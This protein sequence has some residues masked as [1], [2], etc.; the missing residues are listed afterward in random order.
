MRDRPWTFREGSLIGAGLI[1]IG[2]ILQLTMGEVKWDL[3]AYPLNVLLAVIFVV[4]ITIAFLLS[5]K[6]SFFRWCTTITAA[7]PTMLWCAVMTLVMGVTSW[8][9][10][11]R[12][13]PMVLCYTFMLFILGMTSLK[14]ISHFRIKDI[15]FLL[16][17]VGLFF[18]L[19]A[20]AL[21]NA[22]VQRMRMEVETGGTA[23]MAFDETTHRVKELD[24][25]IELHGFS[26]DE[27][28]AKL[29]LVDNMTGR[30]VPDGN[31]EQ[32]VL[33]DSIVRCRLLDWEIFADSYM[34]MAAQES[35]AD[36]IRYVEWKETGATTAV[37]VVA[38]SIN[39]D[40]ERDGWVS[41][42]SYMFPYQLLRLDDRYSLV[43]PDREPKRFASEVTICTKSGLIKEGIIEVNKPL[44]ADGW[45][46][47][48]LSYDES[49]GRWSDV[50]V[51]EL[52]RDPWLP[53]VYA[54]II[55]MLTG[56]I[57][58]FATAG[59]RRKEERL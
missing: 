11:L 7:I 27:Y 1:I 16:N 33:E 14:H 18:A 43:M 35:S 57:C 32:M 2:E 47:Y 4:I 29:M 55:L 51:F 49:M 58:M 19:L 37:H 44:E 56:A 59:V 20:G 52:V 36:T 3:I 13:W 26:I 6:F 5:E 54:E 45:K 15:P 21:G 48:Q 28:P 17:H 39:T 25:T 42:G 50:S 22:D 30:A 8:M 41:C 38:K 9:S 53:F 10:M 34:E 23:R 31:P 24:M 46:V 12:W 40:V